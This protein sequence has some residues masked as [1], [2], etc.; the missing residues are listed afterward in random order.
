MRIRYLS[1]FAVFFC[2]MGCFAWGPRA[3]KYLP[4]TTALQQR[5]DYDGEVIIIGAGAAGLAAARV[6]EENN[7]SSSPACCRYF[8]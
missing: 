7:V 1:K 2:L 4:E 5:Y 6:L 8:N 3:S